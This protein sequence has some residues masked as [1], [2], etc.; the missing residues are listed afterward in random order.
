MRAA[1]TRNIEIQLSEETAQG[2]YSNLAII[3]HSE[4][5][6][7]LDFVFLQPNVPKGKIH[8]RIIMTPDHAKRFQLALEDNLKKF[9][10]KFGEVRLKVEQPIPGLEAL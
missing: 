10:N 2:D 3:N 7:V 8:S 1:D 9:E 4:S 5:E 6:F